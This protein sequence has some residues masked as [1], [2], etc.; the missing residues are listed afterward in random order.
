MET[1]RMTSGRPNGY[2]SFV[3]RYKYAGVTFTRNAK[4][5]NLFRVKSKA[6]RDLEQVVEYIDTLQGGK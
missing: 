5:D 6:F 4:G 3:R 1:P 2:G